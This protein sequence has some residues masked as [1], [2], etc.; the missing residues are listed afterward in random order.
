MSFV[1][2][3][4]LL[5]MPPSSHHDCATAQ[6]RAYIFL[7]RLPIPFFSQFIIFVG[8]KGE[9]HGYHSEGPPSE[10]HVSNE[11]ELW[12]WGR[13]NFEQQALMVGLFLA[14]LLV[15]HPKL[16]IIRA[17][18]RSRRLGRRRSDLPAYSLRTRM[19]I[20]NSPSLVLRPVPTC[21]P[22]SANKLM[23]LRTRKL[24]CILC[25]RHSTYF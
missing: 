1:S 5:E 14:V 21:S 18:V 25:T 13:A 15:H 6:E 24:V 7:A 12:S 20:G 19:R 16:E 23:P 17:S 3:D 10:N 22:C 8:C 2:A 11:L 4:G 9:S